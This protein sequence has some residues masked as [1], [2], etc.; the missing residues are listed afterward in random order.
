MSKE[1]II[2]NIRKAIFESMVNDIIAFTFQGLAPQE[3]EIM[4]IKRYPTQDEKIISKIIE[5]AYK[6]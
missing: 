3:N 1:I 4:I 6:K 5:G 2:N